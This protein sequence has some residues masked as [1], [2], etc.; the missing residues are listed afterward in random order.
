MA[1]EP[2][3]EPPCRPERTPGA[4][5]SLGDRRI[6]LAGEAV[7]Q[8]PQHHLPEELLGAQEQ[9]EEEAEPLHRLEPGLDHPQEQPL[10]GEVQRSEARRNHRP[11]Q[12]TVCRRANK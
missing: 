4:S 9:V 8:H 10:P 11:G 3:E 7:A 12:H 6:H 5:V 2:L 1:R